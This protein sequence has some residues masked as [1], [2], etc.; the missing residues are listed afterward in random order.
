MLK[1][2]QTTASNI[3]NKHEIEAENIKRDHYFIQRKNISKK[4]IAAAKLAYTLEVP[5][6]A[7]FKE[8]N[9]YA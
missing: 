8:T 5:F 7:V 3:V 2:K 4:S 1:E 9:G 6:K